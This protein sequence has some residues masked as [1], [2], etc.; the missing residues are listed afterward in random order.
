[1]QILQKDDLTD[2]RLEQKERLETL[3]EVELCVQRLH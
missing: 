1:M 2:C 3:A